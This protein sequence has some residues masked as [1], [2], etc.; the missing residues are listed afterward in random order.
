M[1]VAYQTSYVNRLIAKLFLILSSSLLFH[2]TNSN[3]KFVVRS[4]HLL[5]RKRIR[6]WYDCINASW[7]D[8]LVTR[9]VC[10]VVGNVRQKPENELNESATQLMVLKRREIKH[11]NDVD[12]LPL[13]NEC[14]EQ[15][16]WVIV[17]NKT[18]TRHQ[19]TV[20]LCSKM[21][22]SLLQRNP[23]HCSCVTFLDRF[24]VPWTG[25]EVVPVLC[26]PLVVETTHRQGLLARGWQELLLE[27][28][29][30]T[31]QSL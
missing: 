17:R 25:M 23:R 9:F 21:L 31:M 6:Q 14:K 22:S 15:V 26:W 2:T 19:W 8:G 13:L 16:G 30:L 11:S 27:T 7:P 4:T 10:G 5:S 29:I 28:W 3:V 20:K 18:R 24:S 12:L 1:W